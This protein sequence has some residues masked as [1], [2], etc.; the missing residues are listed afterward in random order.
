MVPFVPLAPGAPALT[1]VNL[2][3]FVKLG[4]PALLA[5]NVTLAVSADIAV[6]VIVFVFTPVMV[7]PL[8][9]VAYDQLDVTLYNPSYISIVVPTPAKDA[10]VPEESAGSV[11]ISSV[12]YET[13]EP[14]A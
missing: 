3:I 6:T 14:F 1:L 2:N 11:F 12:K 5:V 10:T 8:T 4:Y 7:Q 9:A 13:G